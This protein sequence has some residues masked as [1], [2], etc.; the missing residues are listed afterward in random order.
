MKIKTLVQQNKQHLPGFSHILFAELHLDRSILQLVQIYS[1]VRIVPK[2]VFD[3]GCTEIVGQVEATE[4]GGQ[5]ES[6]DKAKDQGVPV[7][8]GTEFEVDQI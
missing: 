8:V 1:I 7:V 4:T 3:S 6:G 5:C 2:V